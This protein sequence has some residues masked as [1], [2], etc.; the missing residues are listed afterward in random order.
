MDARQI[1][2]SDAFKRCQAFHGHVCGGLAIGYLAA[3]AGLD[4][5]R[6]KRALDEEL[7]AIVETDAC[8]VDAI[9]ALTGCTF[10]KG[11]LI[12]RDYGKMGFTFFNR[13]TGRGV[14]LAMKPDAFRVNDRQITLFRKT[15][16]GSIT[17]SERAELDALGMQRTVDVLN[18][19]AEDLFS[20]SA[21]TAGM[22]DK[23]RIE[24]S[25]P[26]ARCGEPTMASKLETVDGARVCRGCLA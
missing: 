1:M 10:G 25:T 17:D 12:H 20:I 21:V 23:A 7:V 5:L 22:P 11:N 8:C 15:R 3:T 4:W 9:Q 2:D 13:R 18:T 14:R 6:E 26:C 19:R 24:P 16:D